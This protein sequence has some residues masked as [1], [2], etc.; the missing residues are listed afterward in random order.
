MH[1]LVITGMQGWSSNNEGQDEVLALNSFPIPDSRSPTPVLLL[2]DA[3]PSGHARRN[4]G[5]NRRL[6]LLDDQ[7]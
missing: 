2:P 3:H 6:I 4:A 1:G 7:R 5:F